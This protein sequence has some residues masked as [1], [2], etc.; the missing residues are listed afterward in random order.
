MAAAVGYPYDWNFNAYARLR[1]VALSGAEG[2]QNEADHAEPDGTLDPD[3]ANQ[4]WERN[5]FR[6]LH[7]ATRPQVVPPVRLPSAGG[8]GMSNQPD[9]SSD[10]NA[11]YLRPAVSETFKA[12]TAQLRRG[13]RRQTDPGDQG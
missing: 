3:R 11:A 12:K 4:E 5:T 7:Q 1:G 9:V 6:T 2:H 8:P 10:P 13:A